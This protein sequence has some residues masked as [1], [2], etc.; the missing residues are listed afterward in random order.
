[1]IAATLAPRVQPTDVDAYLRVEADGTI[2]LL[3]GKVEFGQ[4]IQTGF[5]QLAAEELDVPFDRINAVMGTTDRAPWDLGTFGSLSTRTTGVTIRRAA[6]ELRRWLLELGAVRL[7]VPIEQLATQDGTVY[8]KADPNRAVGYGE[9]ARGKKVDRPV[10]GGAPLKDPSA[11]TIVGQS[12][13]RVDVP[14]KVDGSMKY[15]YDTTVPGM[16]HGKVIRP[17]SW[18]ATL[19]SVDFSTAERMPGVVGV[20]REGDFAGLVAERHEQAERAAAAVKAT[21]KETGSPYTS[22]NIFD[23]L[24]ATKDQ[25]RSLGATG[26]AAGGLAGAA[27]T[28]SV[29]VTAPYVAHAAIEP[30]AAVANARADTVEIWSS[31]QS[32]FDAQDAVATALDLPRET[33][34]VYPQMSGGAFGRKTLPGAEVEAARLS[35]ALRRPVRVNWNRVEEFQLDHCRPAML[36]ELT[37]GLDGQGRIVGWDWATYATAYYP[38]GARQ[39]TYALADAGAN[40]LDMYDLPSARTTFYQAVAPLPPWFW[41]DNGAPVNALARETALDELAELAGMDPVSFRERILAKNPRLAAVM[42]AAVQKAGW[43]PGVGSTGQGVGIGLDFQD[44]TYVA[45]VAR[46]A[47]DRATGKVRVERVDVAIDCGLVVNPDAARCQIEGSVV[48]QGT[49]SALKE[50]I[51]FA[52]GKVLTHSFA[53]YGPVTFREAPTVEVVFVEDKAQPP[54]G[55]GEPAVGGVPAA[56][57]NAIY[58]AVG[59][60][61]RDLPFRPDRVLAALKAG[62]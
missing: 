13:P 16:V 15:G 53:A 2:T 33:V 44:D 39:P 8:L 11:Y 47:V 42:R 55:I 60:R 48:M 41:R 58:D 38:D 34:I 54:R 62:D 27:K 1:V 10:N 59:V 50:E 9:L 43:T 36:V 46:V 56:I 6:A 4:G 20:F 49:S 37:A 51:R 12:I 30:L 35:R 23:A 18:G 22:E 17:P 32:P 26:D 21:W 61:L 57:S 29:R 3:T 31:T 14:L 45:E 25:G 7:G 19:E 52:G 40:V 24:K 5:A 28:I